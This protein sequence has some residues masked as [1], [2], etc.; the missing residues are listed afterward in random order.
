MK[1]YIKSHDLPSLVGL[2]RAVKTKAEFPFVIWGPL[3]CVMYMKY[4]KVYYDFGHDIT[5]L[6]PIRVAEIHPWTFMFDIA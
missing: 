5:F 6:Q 1:L 2:P 4:F 3:L